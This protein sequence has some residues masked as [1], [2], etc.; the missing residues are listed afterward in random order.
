MNLAGYFQRL[1]RDPWRAE[2]G[3]S[4]DLLSVLET[5]QDSATDD[6]GIIQSLNGWLAEHQPCLFGRAAARKGS[7]SYCILREQ[8]LVGED[9]AVRTKIQSDRLEWKRRAL[10]GE[11]SGFIIVVV[12]PALAY[13]APDK[14]VFGIA[15][16]LCEL[17][18]LDD[19]RENTIYTDRLH[20]DVPGRK[21]STFEW[22]VGANYFS[23]QG[24]QRWWLD[25]RFPAGMAFSM[26]SVGHLVR[27]SVVTKALGEFSAAVG[28]EDE[29]S[30]NAAIDS[31]DKALKFAMMTIANAQPAP[32][33]P[34]TELKDLP[35]DQSG[36][37][38]CPIELPSSLAG[39]DYCVYHG[40]Y[41]TDVT[42]PEEY[43]RPDVNWPDGLP[44]LDL[45]F[46]YLFDGSLDNPAFKTMGQGLQVRAD[47]EVNASGPSSYRFQKR[48]RSAGGELG[49]KE[50]ARLHR[51]LDGG[52]ITE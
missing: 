19:I 6:A 38:K 8:D 15:R 47:G 35:V 18:L 45:D 14:T 33:G 30:P 9:E 34:A 32:S 4:S 7:L 49:E 20:L 42:L 25:H 13:A 22:A 36:R 16:R 2:V 21:L 3:F 12:S 23:A 27:S 50:I 52:Q 51:D 44:I 5:T 46:T 39:K 40:R 1:Q 26:N 10:R 11:A 48:L 29:S 31:L 43:F 41:H 37:P 28:V 24:D 17:Y